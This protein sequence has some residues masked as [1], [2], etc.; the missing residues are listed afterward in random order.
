MFLSGFI[1]GFIAGANF[2]FIAAFLFVAAGKES[3]IEE[4][5]GH[6]ENFAGAGH[7]MVY[8]MEPAMEMGKGKIFLRISIGDAIIISKGK[9]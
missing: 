5:R 8:G 2:G 9:L 6:P 4:M 7:I 1:L 3:R